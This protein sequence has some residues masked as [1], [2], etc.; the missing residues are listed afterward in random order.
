MNHLEVV[1]RRNH[2]TH[3]LGT[4][5]LPTGTGIKVVADAQQSRWS[6]AVTLV[7]HVDLDLV[8]GTMKAS[9]QMDK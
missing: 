4:I 2:D 6:R 7:D 3:K 9:K 1:A 8:V 5:F